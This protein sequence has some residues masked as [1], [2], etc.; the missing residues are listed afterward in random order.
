[1]RGGKGEVSSSALRICMVRRLTEIVDFIDGGEWLRKRTS[2]TLIR[3]GLQE[4]MNMDRGGGCETGDMFVEM[5]LL[6]LCLFVRV[7]D[8]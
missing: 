3:L 2:V 4:D 6:M 5:G 8:V 7:R 1:M